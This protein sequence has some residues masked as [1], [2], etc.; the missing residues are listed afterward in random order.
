MS[1]FCCCCFVAIVVVVVVA[2]VVVVVVVVFQKM[3]SESV[4]FDSYILQKYNEDFS[5]KLKII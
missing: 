1:A 3:T 4:N 5:T 2:V